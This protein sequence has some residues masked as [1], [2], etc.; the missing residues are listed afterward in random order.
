MAAL[1]EGQDMLHYSDNSHRWIAP[2]DT[3][4][5]RWDERLQWHL[6]Q[7]LATMGGPTDLRE[8]RYAGARRVDD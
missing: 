7:H 2:P 5:E 8:Y 1:R 4:Q 6:D 3:D